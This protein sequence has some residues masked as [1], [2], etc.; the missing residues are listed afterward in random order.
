MARGL[1]H[2]HGPQGHIV[3]LAVPD[4]FL[5]SN[6]IISSVFAELP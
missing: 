2:Q 6:D 5:V 4:G 3:A 1:V